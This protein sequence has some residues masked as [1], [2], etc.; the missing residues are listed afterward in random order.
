VKLA[1]VKRESKN[2]MEACL[3]QAVIRLESGFQSYKSGRRFRARCLG[4]RFPR[5][6]VLLCLVLLRYHLGHSAIR[7]IKTGETK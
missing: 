6:H 1:A 3:E 4:I 2:L 5:V 7:F